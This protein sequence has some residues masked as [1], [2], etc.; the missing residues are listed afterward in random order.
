MFVL[1]P[2]A[3]LHQE[4]VFDSPT[5]AR[6][7]IAALMHVLPAEGGARQPGVFGTLLDNLRR[8]RIHRFPAFLADHHVYDL[9]LSIVLAVVVFDVVDPPEVLFTIAPRPV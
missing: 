5:M 3:F 6:A 8:L 2:L 9:L 7:E 4:G 1:I